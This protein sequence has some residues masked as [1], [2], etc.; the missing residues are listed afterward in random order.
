[1][2]TTESLLAS[3]RNS[4]AFFWKHADRFEGDAWDHRIALGTKTARETLQH[5][6]ADDRAVLLSLNTGEEPDYEALA[7]DESDPEKL[8]A[9][10]FASHV[11][12]LEALAWR[13]EQS[14]INVWG[15]EKP[16]VE[17]IAWYASEDFY[18]AGQLAMILLALNPD[19]AYY[20]DVYGE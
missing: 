2:S 9:M 8:K 14:V 19:W 13:R 15:T 5:L 1:M 16:I 4:R 6:L 3:L 17:G 20:P 11:E 10:L 18:H 7:P 12:L